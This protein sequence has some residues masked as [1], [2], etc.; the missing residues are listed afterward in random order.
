M[1]SVLRFGGLDVRL[2]L[3]PYVLG[4]VLLVVTPALMSVGLAFTDYD[5][6]APPTFRGFGNFAELFAEPLFWTALGNSLFFVIFAVPLRVAAALALALLM[7]RP[8]RGIGAYRAS[9]YLPTVVPD[10]AY[11]FVWLWILNPLYGPLN[12]VLGALDLPTPA[13]LADSETAKFGFVLMSLFQIG[14]G[15]VILLAGLS[16]VPDTYREAAAVDGASR[17]QSF[18][19]IVLPL[20]FPWLLLLGVRDVALG[21]QYTFAPSYLMTGGDPYFSTL[22]LPLLI[23]EEAFDRFRYGL[24]AAAMVLMFLGIAML[25]GLLYV[26]LRRRAIAVEEA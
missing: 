25:V 23:Y 7:E 26:V 1:R 21:F 14:E 15:F 2:L 6:L 11:A 4:T 12:L 18:R 16:D 9:V 24:G 17:W 22:F 8:S 5:A 20:L 3:V 19:H 10:V 13:W